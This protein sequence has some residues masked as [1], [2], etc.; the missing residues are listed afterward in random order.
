M[1][2]LQGMEAVGITISLDD[3]KLVFDSLDDKGSGLIN[4]AQFCKLD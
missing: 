4:F 3:A 1:E 2:F